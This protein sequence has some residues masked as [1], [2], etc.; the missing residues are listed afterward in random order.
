MYKFSGLPGRPVY[1]HAIMSP[2]KFDAYGSGYFSG[3]GDILYDFDNQTPEEQ[4]SRK[5]TLKKHL[6]DLMIVILRASDHLKEVYRL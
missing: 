5:L 3:I 4:E 6:S 2:A 1:N